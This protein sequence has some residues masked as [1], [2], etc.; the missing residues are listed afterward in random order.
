MTKRASDATDDQIKKKLKVEIPQDEQDALVR[1]QTQIEE[2]E[3]ACIREQLAIQVKFDAKKQ[4]HFAERDS[5]MAKLGLWPRALLNQG[6]V[7]SLLVSGDITILSD[8]LESV[9]LNDHVDE[10]GSFEMKFMFKDDVKKVFTPTTLIKK[11]VYTE[12]GDVDESKSQVTDVA[13]VNKTENPVVEAQQYRQA[14]E[15]EEEGSDDGALALPR[16][17]FFEWVSTTSEDVLPGF[18]EYFRKEI[19]QAPLAAVFG[20]DVSD[21]SDDEDEE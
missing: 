2:L 11:I 15:E 21:Q 3:E 16:W 20:S 5:L 1:I 8:Y 9:S 18:S 7:H 10:N 6:A 17:S 14:L 4:P 12:D 13:F 19:Y